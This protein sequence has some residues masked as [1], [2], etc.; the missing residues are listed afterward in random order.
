[1]QV[2]NLLSKVAYFA[3]H[4][5]GDLKNAGHATQFLT[6]LLITEHGGLTEQEK[7]HAFSFFQ[8]LLTQRLPWNGLH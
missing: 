7:G 3:A 4:V 1:M 2:G 6:D 8:R 5:L